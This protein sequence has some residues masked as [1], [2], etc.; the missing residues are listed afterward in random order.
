MIVDPEVITFA[1]SM[2]TVLKV[3]DLFI[4]SPFHERYFH[5][6]TRN[7]IQFNN[8]MK[9]FE[10]GDNSL[11]SYLEWHAKNTPEPMMTRFD[12]RIEITT[13]LSNHSLATY[14]FLKRFFLQVI[15]LVLLNSKTKSKI[16]TT[17]TLGSILEAVS[18][19]PNINPESL[20]KF[21]DI[22][23]RNA[24]AHDSWYLDL[25]GMRYLNPDNS[26]ILI[27]YSKLQEKSSIIIALYSTITSEYFKIYYPEVVQY[28]EKE[29]GDE[30]A[31]FFFPLY[32]M[33]SH[34]RNNR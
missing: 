19:L 24:L 21:F 8:L 30:E 1:K 6:L 28:Y 12:F 29:G 3:E 31:N 13:L 10:I 17:S 20:S 14:E 18:K 7:M 23:F 16:K 4:K 11:D 25:D 9:K 34:E 5:Q 27:P 26:L 32:G 22:D 15:N 33:N 2:F